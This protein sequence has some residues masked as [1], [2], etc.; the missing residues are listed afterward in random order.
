MLMKVTFIPK[1]KVVHER[2]TLSIHLLLYKSKKPTLGGNEE[3]TLSSS[4]VENRG[5]YGISS[6]VS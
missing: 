1:W 3:K 6:M 4:N 2:R 5:L